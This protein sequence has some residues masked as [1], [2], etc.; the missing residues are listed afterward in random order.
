MQLAEQAL[1]RYYETGASWRVASGL[2]ALGVT[3]THAERYEEALG[4]LCE[5]LPIFRDNWQRLGEGITHY[6]MTK[7]HLGASKSA[8]AA[9]HAEQALTQLACTGGE[10]RRGNVLMVLGR[11]LDALGHVHRARPAGRKPDD[12]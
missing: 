12:L 5:A 10:W 11:S 7:L 2:Y 8:Q 3:L 9:F 1:A 6:R 4:R